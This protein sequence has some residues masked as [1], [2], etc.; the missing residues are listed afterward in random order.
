MLFSNNQRTDEEYEDLLNG[1]DSS[2]YC[3][4]LVLSYEAARKGYEVDSL[5]R[6]QI[7]DVFDAYN[8]ASAYGSITITYY[9]AFLRQED[10]WN[11]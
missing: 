4:A 9:D 6:D 7:E 1:K 5:N 8:G 11:L 3:G 2:I 10:A